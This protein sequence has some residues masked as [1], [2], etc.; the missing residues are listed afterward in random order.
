M[1]SSYDDCVHPDDFNTHTMCV[2][3]FKLNELSQPF[4]VDKPWKINLMISEFKQQD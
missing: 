3:V 2:D 1:I 4:W